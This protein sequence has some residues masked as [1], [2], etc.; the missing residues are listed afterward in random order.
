VC[1]APSKD[2]RRVLPY[3]NYSHTGTLNY[4]VIFMVP[5]ETMLATINLK[6]MGTI[7]YQNLSSTHPYEVICFSS[8]FDIPIEKI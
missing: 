2:F 1:N 8:S 6:L 7:T 4:E 5:L 3:Q